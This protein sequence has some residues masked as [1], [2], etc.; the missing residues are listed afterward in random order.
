MINVAQTHNSSYLGSNLITDGTL[1]QLRTLADAHE[2]SLAYNE[3]ES[4]ADNVRA[5]SAMVLAEEIVEFLNN[6]IAGVGKQKIGI[7]FGAYATFASFFG[8][9]QLHDVDPDFRGVAQY[10]SSMV[11]E[12]FTNSSEIVSA[13]EY[14]SADAMYVRFLF[15]NG[16]ATNESEPVGYP[17]FGSSEEVITWNDFVNESGK[18]SIRS[19]EKWCDLCRNTDGT[20]AAYASENGANNGADC[21]ASASCENNCGNGLTPAVNGVIGAMVTLAAILGIGGLILS[22]GGFTIVR[23][24]SL[25]ATAVASVSAGEIKSAE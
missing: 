6:T 24:K 17:L 3:S 9:A 14:P 20:C 7:Q 11:F 23:K 8:L 13:D 22:I 16:T 18:F 2:W 21:P 15:S 10:A 5:V 19:T 1:D 4:A 12:L 25:A